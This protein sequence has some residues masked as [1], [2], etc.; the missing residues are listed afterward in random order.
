MIFSYILCY[1][2]LFCSA[3]CINITNS[4]TDT[5][6][7]VFDNVTKVNVLLLKSHYDDQSSMNMQ[8]QICQL[9]QGEIYIMEG[10]SFNKIM[11]MYVRFT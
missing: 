4:C 7:K 1:H 3:I 10:K 11:H 5:T 8:I 9:M 6:Q 2:Q